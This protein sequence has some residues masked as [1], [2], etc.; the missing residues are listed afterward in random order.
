M[1]LVL[2]AAVTAQAV[3]GLFVVEHNDATAG[4]L[5]RLI[6][7]EGRRSSPAGTSGSSTG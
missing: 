5:Y 1:I 2:L 7:E 4:P 3:S 6:S